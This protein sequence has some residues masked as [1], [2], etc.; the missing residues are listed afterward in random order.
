MGLMPQSNLHLLLLYSRFVLHIR[1]RPGAHT[2]SME[3][4]FVLL[5]EF[6]HLIFFMCVSSCLLSGFSP[7]LPICS[8]VI[9]CMRLLLL[10][11]RIK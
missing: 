9:L 1:Y 8:L 7:D 2:L 10:W 5:F 4:V 11:L 6:F 3:P